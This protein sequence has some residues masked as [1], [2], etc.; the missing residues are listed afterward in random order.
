MVIVERYVTRE[1][2]EYGHK[3]WCE[4]CRSNPTEVYSVQLDRV[5]DL[6]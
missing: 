6:K 1:K 3:R 5:I 4:F 2:M